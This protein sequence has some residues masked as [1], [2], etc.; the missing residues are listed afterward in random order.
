[1]RGSVSKV[2]RKSGTKWQARVDLPR[3]PDDERRRQ[4]R[5]FDTKR[6]AERW[7]TEINHEINQGGYIEPADTPFRLFLDDWLEDYA[8][9]NVK[10]STYDRYSGTIERHLKPALGDTPLKDITPMALQRFY[11]EKLD[12][13]RLDG[14]DGGLS[15]TTVRQFHN[16]LHKVFETA[17][18]WGLVKNN[19]AKAADPPKRA[20][21]EMQYLTPDQARAFIEACEEP[22]Q[23]YGD[24]FK[25]AV[26]TGLRRGELLGLRWQDLDLQNNV[27]SIRQTLVRSTEGNLRFQ[28]PKSSTGERTVALTH[29]VI[30]TL[31]Q[32]RERQQEKREEVGSGWQG[33]DHDLVFTNAVGAP[34]DPSNLRRT[35]DKVLEENDLPMI[36]F[37]DLRH[38]HATLMLRNGEHPKVVS[39]RLGHSRVQITLDR[40]SHVLPNMQDEAAQDLEDFLY[41]GRAAQG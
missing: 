40:Y 4:S 11:T 36:R 38:T 10:P 30:H 13:G 23:R 20:E 24:L 25:L 39:E 37:H 34:V 3:G 19:P 21:T 7:L 12:G 6:E 8:K 9:G 16:L 1:M 32:H 15:P 28:T 5:T 2:E 31:Q 35:Y 14:Q 29:R 27:A 18:K 22:G 41:E 17:R 26:L 33:E